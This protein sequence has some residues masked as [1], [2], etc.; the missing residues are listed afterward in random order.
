MGSNETPAPEEALGPLY[1]V[2]ERGRLTWTA[3]GL[4]TYRARFARFGFRVEAITTRDELRTALNRSA[5]G[6]TDQLLALVGNGPRSLERNLL[7]AIARQDDA[8]YRRLFALV[9]A[10]NRLGLRVVG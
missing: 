10:R 3:D 4:Q 1:L 2:D 9:E 8:E 6:L 5:A 7:V